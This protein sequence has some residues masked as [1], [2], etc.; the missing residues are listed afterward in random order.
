MQRF[1]LPLVIAALLAAACT[2]PAAPPREEGLKIQSSIPPYYSHHGPKVDVGEFSEG[3]AAGDKDT[4]LETV[5]AMRRQWDSLAVMPMYVAA[6][7]LL[8]VGEPRQAAYWYQGAKYRAAL[9]VRL[10]DRS[11]GTNRMGSEAYSRSRAHTAFL[12]LLQPYIS[13]YA[14]CDL[15]TYVETVNKAALENDTPIRFRRIYPDIDFLPESRWAEPAGAVEKH[16]RE[17]TRR[18]IQNY[19]TIVEQRKAAGIHQTYCTG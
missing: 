7:R 17:Q 13:R 16:F 5:A 14:L 3:L 2:K 1:S 18:I 12:K 9:F 6:L 4:L 19:D 11:T 8:E 10:L 15:Q